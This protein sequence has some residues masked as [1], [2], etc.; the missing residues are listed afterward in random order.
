M[1]ASLVSLATD[2]GAPLVVKALS[3]KLGDTTG[4]IAGEVL[5]VIAD[6]AGVE[7]RALDT[8]AQ[9]HPD[10][11]SEAIS[12][13][14]TVM[15]ELIR[16]YELE[17][18][19]GRLLIEAERQDPVWTRAWRPLGMYLLGFLWLWSVVVLHAVNAIFKTALPPMDYSVLLQ[20]SGL[21]MALYMGGHTVKDFTTKWAGK[22]APGDE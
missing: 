21:Y 6:H 22:G 8:A 17:A 1:T 15:P 12:Q 9:E 2:I 18:E 10:V 19:N 11:I 20:L 3:N 7:T 14:E 4:K 5:R 16:V 13:A